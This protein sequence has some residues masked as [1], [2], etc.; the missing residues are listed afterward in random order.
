MP[1]ESALQLA[2]LAMG[3][4]RCG[5]DRVGLLSGNIRLY[6]ADYQ[7]FDQFGKIAGTLLVGQRNADE[8]AGPLYPT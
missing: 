5:T 7:V 4:G 6:Q 2:H 3:D 1:G 8:F